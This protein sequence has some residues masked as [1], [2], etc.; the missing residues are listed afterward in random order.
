MAKPLWRHQNCQGSRLAP[1]GT[2]NSP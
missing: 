2:L 1:H